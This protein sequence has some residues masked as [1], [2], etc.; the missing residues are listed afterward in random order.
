MKNSDYM[1]LFFALLLA[2]LLPSFIGQSVTKAA[3]SRQ[4]QYGQYL[5]NACQAALEGSNME[6][7]L[8]FGT[9][10]EREGATKAFFSSLADSLNATNTTSEA[11]I[12]YYVPVIL[13]IDNDGFYAVYQ[14]YN[15]AAF[16]QRMTPL[17]P[18]A[19]EFYGNNVR[20]FLDGEVEV[21][22]AVAKETRHFDSRQQA[23]DVFPGIPFF[24]DEEAFRN[25]ISHT[26]ISQVR[27]T[28][29][30]YINQHNHYNLLYDASYT[31]SLPEVSGQD[32]AS[33]MDGPCVLSFL[34]GVKDSYQKGHVN[35]YA[36]AGS[37]ME[38]H[39]YYVM[40][41]DAAGEKTYHLPGCSQAVDPDAFYNS[42][43]QAALDGAWP[44]LEC[45]PF[46]P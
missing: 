20:F 22:D 46:I 25:E 32:W 31:F 40:T 17:V 35:V 44:C 23:Q 16:E 19:G 3:A 9:Q 18:Y 1:I 21:T 41:M 45:I 26:A 11:E 28:A 15:G 8:A 29:E 42:M 36:L 4:T 6:D 14:E 38:R 2:I 7:G 12:P 33:L 27:Q 10:A 13:L 43:Q 37:R 24:A 30:Y 5:T 39:T 34:Q